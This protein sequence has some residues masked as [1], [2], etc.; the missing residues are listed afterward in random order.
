MAFPQCWQTSVHSHDIETDGDRVTIRWRHNGFLDSGDRLARLASRNPLVPRTEDT[1]PLLLPVST[2]IRGPSLEAE[3][4]ETPGSSPIL[5]SVRGWTWGPLGE[6]I[7][8][9]LAIQFDQRFSRSL[10]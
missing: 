7:R 1:K 4:N 9:S 3:K 8:V 6:G 5:R 10:I 2:K